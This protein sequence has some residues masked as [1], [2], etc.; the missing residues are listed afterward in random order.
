M[1]HLPGTG[2]AVLV[3]YGYV[4]P[5]PPVASASAL[6]TVVRAE[7]LIFRRGD[8]WQVLTFAADAHSFVA[9]QWIWARARTSLSLE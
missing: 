2:P 9:D 7:D 4:A 8:R 3:E 1:S 5:P 6:P